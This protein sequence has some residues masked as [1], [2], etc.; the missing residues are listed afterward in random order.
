VAVNASDR[1]AERVLAR[2]DKIAACSETPGAITRRY[3]TPALAAAMNLVA[4]WMRDAGLAVRRDGIGNLIGRLP[5]ANG[6]PSAPV[7]VLGSH[8]DSVPNGGRYDGPLGVLLA[9]E[10]VAALQLPPPFAIEV[11]A[12]ADEEGARFH[13][14]YLGSRAYAGSFD[15]ALLDRTDVD[16]I[17]LREAC[18]GFGGDPAALDAGIPPPT[19]LLGYLEVHIEQGPALERLQA[20][21]GIVT[22]IAGQTRVAVTLSG[23]AGHAG[24][25]AMDMRR[26]ALAAAAELV[27]EAERLARETPDLLATVG[28]LV[29]F[30]GASNVIPGAV[31][32]SLD[33]R[34]PDDATRAAGLVLLHDACKS[35]AGKRSVRVD[36]RLVQENAATAMDQALSDALADALRRAGLSVH[37]LPSGA[38]HD[39]VVMSAICPTAMLFVRCR[40]GI[41]HHPDES[42]AK[43]D[44]ALAA[45]VLESTIQAFVDAASAATRIIAT[46][47]A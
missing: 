28:Q 21:L 20:P 18:A 23:E 5:A 25:G 30:P 44:V 36:W 2:C 43:T 17:S 39:A 47:D 29:V 3:G 24:T 32:L 46:G 40:G 4:E 16:G 26:D 1:V 7:L 22:A 14:T 15:P 41:S 13:T 42:V 10:V 8:V 37:R 6:S 27:L 35:A 45:T 19:N 31:Q 9:L 34:S 38:G 11:V 12:F 33:V